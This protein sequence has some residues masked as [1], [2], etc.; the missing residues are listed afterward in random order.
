MSEADVVSGMVRN[1]TKKSARSEVGAEVSVY[2]FRVCSSV[3]VVHL[4][5]CYNN[6][7][8]RTDVNNGGS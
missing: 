5:V 2:S 6:M 7:M 8:Q 1:G 4:T 3:S